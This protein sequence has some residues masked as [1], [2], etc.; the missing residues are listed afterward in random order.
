M[1]HV[2]KR[3]RNQPIEKFLARLPGVQAELQ[4][5]ATSAATRARALLLKHRDE[6][7][8]KITVDRGRIDRYVVLEDRAALS[9]EYG[10]K[11]NENG[12]GGM[13]G[14]YIL[15]RAFDLRRKR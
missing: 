15:H 14:L 9:I 2:Y 13:E 8:A 11:P 5:Q 12:R 3:V 4:S 6:G 1:A 10:R 7:V